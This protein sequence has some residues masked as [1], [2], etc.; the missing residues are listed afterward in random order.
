MGPRRSRRAIAE[1]AAW[2]DGPT[3]DQPNPIST[4]S[5]LR[6]GYPNRDANVLEGRGI[7]FRSDVGCTVTTL[8]YRTPA[9]PQR[10]PRRSGI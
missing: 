7:R 3:V 10:G 1:E 2:I 9:S 5:V 8:D 4:R 6:P